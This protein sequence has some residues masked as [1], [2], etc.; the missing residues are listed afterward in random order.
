[1]FLSVNLS[2]LRLW[3]NT[4]HIHLL[5][6]VKGVIQCPA[7]RD[8]DSC[9]A[10][11]WRLTSL[12]C[13][14]TLEVLKVTCNLRVTFW[15]LSHGSSPAH[16]PPADW[17]QFLQSLPRWARFPG[18]HSFVC[19]LGEIVWNCQP[20]K[21]A[22]RTAGDRSQKSLLRAGLKLHIGTWHIMQ[23]TKESN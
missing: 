23:S 17:Q 14:L 15:P 6:K 21:R 22:P 1:M 3:K 4:G 5:N 18:R 11:C 8:L 20:I 19:T 10:I 13:S 7:S 12:L 9:L 16:L 2:L